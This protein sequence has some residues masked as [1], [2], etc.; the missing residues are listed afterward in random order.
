MIRLVQFYDEGGARRV[1]LSSGDLGALRLLDGFE[2]VFDLAR[3]AIH[4]GETL[5]AFVRPRLTDNVADYDRV[6]A[7][8]RLLPPLDHP[9]PARCL[10]SLTG[11]THLGSAASRDRMHAES[12]PSTDNEVET[13]SLR[14][15]RIG[16]EGG[17]PGAGRIGAQPEWAY[18]GDG[19]CIVPP[20]H[21]L[22][23]PGY[24]EDG[25]EEAE[26]AGLYVIGDDGAPWRIGYALGNEFADHVL[27]KRNYLYLAHSKLREC[28][29]G[30]ELWVGDLPERVLG[31]VRILRDGETVWVSPFESGEAAMCHSIAN[32]EHH[33][34]KYELFRR[35]GDAHVHFFGANGVSFGDGFRTEDGDVFEIDVPLFG[36][37]LRNP[38]R[39]LP[40]DP[41]PVRVRAL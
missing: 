15:F 38:L 19:R 11:L 7:E 24:A 29:L 9:D 34:F 35:P 39:V 32:L 40:P 5:E 23:Q 6:V 41:N 12:S 4:A 2:R 25:G 37:P 16:M 26:I 1:G 27:E 10:V 31:T 30:P 17:K 14:M 13:D 36:R 8:R 22:T 20:E 33:Q 21:P 18:K 3:A 28:S